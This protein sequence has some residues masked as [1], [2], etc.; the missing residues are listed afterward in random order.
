MH[1]NNVIAEVFSIAGKYCAKLISVFIVHD[2]GKTIW[3]LGQDLPVTWFL[4]SVHN[5]SVGDVVTSTS[6]CALWTKYGLQHVTLYTY[7]Y[8]YHSGFPRRGSRGISDIP[9]RHPRF[10]KIT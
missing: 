9:P 10:T 8:T 6:D 5:D 4:I 7:I 2:C 3:F 1:E